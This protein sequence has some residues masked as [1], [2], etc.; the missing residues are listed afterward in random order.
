[1]DQTPDFAPPFPPDAPPSGTARI[2]AELRQVR[3]RLGWPL[4]D[5]ATR[6]RIRLPYLEAIEQ[7]D[8]N[9]LPGPAYQTGFIRSYAQTLGLDSDE[10]L[11]R[12]R[13][14]GSSFAAKPELSFLAPVPDRAVPSGAVILLGVILVLAGYGAWYWHTERDRK[15][16]TTVMSV[17]AELVPLTVPKP[18]QIPPASAPK[19]PAKVLAPVAPAATTPAAPVGTLAASTLASTPTP[20]L[21]PALAIAATAD[22]WVE[23]KDPT[24]AILFSKT[25]HPGESWPVPNLPGLTMTAGNAAATIIITNGKAS[26][27]L[28]TAGRVIHNDPLTPPAASP[29]SPPSP[30]PPAPPNSKPATAN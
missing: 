13:A 25:L 19:T 8:L 30:K 26:P 29:A 9:A 21:A 12:F 2:G 10:I 20:A 1:M 16:A 15:L 3:E 22:D 11:R 28:G 23:V 4:P 27:P 14:E 6:L 17:P 5:L 18:S 7:G 24:G